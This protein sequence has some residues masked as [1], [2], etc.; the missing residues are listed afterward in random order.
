MYIAISILI[1][2]IINELNIQQNKLYK[3]NYNIIDSNDKIIIHKK[4]LVDL[5]NKKQNNIINTIVSNIKH[6][7]VYNADRGIKNY[8]WVS[9]D[10]QLND[11][12]YEKII[13]NLI[14]IFPDV[15]MEEY[16]KYNIRLEWSK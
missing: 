6:A 5:V 2:L 11:D 7:V 4:T 16:N 14:E 13:N 15:Q 3:H 12:M 1:I 10:Y 8:E 9:S